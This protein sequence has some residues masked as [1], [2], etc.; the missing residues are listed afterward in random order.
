MAFH[1]GGIVRFRLDPNKHGI[2][3]ELTADKAF[4]SIMEDAGERRE[5]F[6]LVLLEEKPKS[7]SAFEVMASQPPGSFWST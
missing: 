3:L 2:V 5:W 1:V 4:L 6:E 7:R